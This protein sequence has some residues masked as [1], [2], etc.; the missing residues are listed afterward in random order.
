M[1][2]LLYFP[3]YKLTF[4][5]YRIPP[6]KSTLTYNYGDQTFD[7]YSECWKNYAVLAKLLQ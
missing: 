5:V 7:G 3:T 4:L 1:N 2:E 6:E